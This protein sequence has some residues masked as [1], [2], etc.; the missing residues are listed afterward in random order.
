MLFSTMSDEEIDE[1]DYEYH[2]PGLH[3]F[4]PDGISSFDCT[5]PSV[6]DSDLCIWHH[7]EKEKD[8]Q[9][10]IEARSSQPESLNGAYLRDLFLN[11]VFHSS[12]GEKRRTFEDC[13][14][15][16]CIL[17]SADLSAAWLISVDFTEATLIDADLQ[18]ARLESAVLHDVNARRANFSNALLSGADFSN[19]N[20]TDAT[21][22]DSHLSRA[23]LS[24][25]VISNPD[26]KESDLENVNFTE[27]SISNADFTESNIDSIILS[28]VHASGS[29]NLSGCDLQECDLSNAKLDLVDLTNA[30]LQRADLS[31]AHLGYTDLSGADLKDATLDDAYL[32]GANLD[33][34]NLRDASLR[35]TVLSDANLRD[36]DAMFADFSESSLYHA[37]FSNSD[38]RRAK[39]QDSVLE[40]VNFQNVDL[41]GTNLKSSLLYNTIFENSIITKQTIFDADC[42]YETESD[43]CLKE[44]AK[45]WGLKTQNQVNSL[46]KAEWVY[47]RLEKLHDE[48]ALSEEVR[49]FHISKEEAERKRLREDIREASWWERETWGTAGLW[50]TKTIMKHISNH[51]ESVKRVLGAWAIVILWF[52]L[53][54]TVSGGIKD[55]EGNTYWIPITS[56][57]DLA[58]WSG[59]ETLFLNLYFSVI[60]FSTLGYGDLS[61]H[62]PLSRTF[63]AV[64]SLAGAVLVALLIYVLGRRVAR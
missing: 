28:D 23:D 60:T 19:A 17:N 2:P 47:R 41:R 30:D 52:W 45:E 48:N 15:R 8:P 24:Q 43:D 33:E 9:T 55:T 40:G 44:R 35:N 37:D 6:T 29:V 7:Q 16:S 34:A 31:G 62:G 21:F 51:G 56:L 3:E 11:N 58:T 50:G 49:Q 36:I 1:C 42:V 54:F 4:I 18:N 22:T 10:I 20:L 27:A 39:F 12:V 14:F 26:F 59:I 25:T 32:M 46:E 57:S 13:H 38:L 61:P 63:V 5:R 53:L 64:E